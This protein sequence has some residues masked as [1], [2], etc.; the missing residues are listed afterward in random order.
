MQ[1]PVAK[2]VQFFFQKYHF[3]F[4]SD[5]EGMMKECSNDNY[6]FDSKHVSQMI[7]FFKKKVFFIQINSCIC[8]NLL[9]KLVLKLP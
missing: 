8:I 9:I 3:L 7:F 6:N 5:C 2:T 4:Q 1:Q